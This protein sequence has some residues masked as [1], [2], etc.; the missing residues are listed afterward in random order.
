MHCITW[1]SMTAPPA[2]WFEWKDHIVVLGPQRSPGILVV[3]GSIIS[4]KPIGDEQTRDVSAIATLC[5]SQ[6]ESLFTMSRLSEQKNLCRYIEQT[7]RLSSIYPTVL[8]A[9]LR[10]HTRNTMMLLY[11]TPSK[12]QDPTAL[13]CTAMCSLHS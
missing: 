6:L 5:A 1:L 8:Y 9:P 10:K 12:K 3:Q 11:S 7:I 4:C 2:R 13:A